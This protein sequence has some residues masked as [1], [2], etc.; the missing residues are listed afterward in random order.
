M[1]DLQGLQDADVHVPVLHRNF[2]YTSEQIRQIKRTSGPLTN[3]ALWYAGACANYNQPVTEPFNQYM[4]GITATTF[5]NNYPAFTDTNNL[6]LAVLIK[7]GAFSILFP[8][9]L[10]RDGWRALLQRA[11]F[12]E[13]LRTLDV[14]VASHHG[15]ENGFCPELFNYCR[16]QAIVISDKPIQ[17]ETQRTLP[18]YR[19]VTTDRGVFVRTTGKMR[20]VL[21]TRRDGTIQFDVAGDGLF[22]I[23]TECRG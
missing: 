1:S 6:S 5:Y 22:S 3:D 10:E 14:L 16:P 17:H 21:T 13:A 20:H 12:R 11:D 19:A 2:S 15:R 4:G 18:D 9:D 8:G 23:I 7:Y